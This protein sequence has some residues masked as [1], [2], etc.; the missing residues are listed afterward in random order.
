MW[1]VRGEGCGEWS[2]KC[3]VCAEGCVGCV[4]GVSV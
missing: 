3:R 4:R 2:K 1:S